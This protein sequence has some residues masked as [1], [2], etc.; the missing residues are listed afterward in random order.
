MLHLKD[1]EVQR[2]PTT[3]SGDGDGVQLRIR[4]SDDDA[5]P[6]LSKAFHQLEDEVKK[7]LTLWLDTGES[8][9]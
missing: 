8:F 9:P 5:Q 1:I 7:A 3:S 2:A 4:F 6:K